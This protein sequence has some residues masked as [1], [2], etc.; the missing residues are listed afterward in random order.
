MRGVLP[1]ERD[2]PA[3]AFNA[4]PRK[5]LVGEFLRADPAFSVYHNT[6]GQDPRALD[7]RLP[8]DLARDPFNIGAVGLVYLGQVA[9]GGSSGLGLAG[10]EIWSRAGGNASW[11]LR[12]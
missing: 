10:Y 1:G 2:D 4:E 5:V 3:G 7:D 6:V 9:H 12:R 8:G 11:S